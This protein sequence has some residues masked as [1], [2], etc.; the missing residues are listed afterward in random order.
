MV[1][2][3]IA[4][5]CDVR[6]IGVRM[7]Q[8]RI[9]GCN[10]LDTVFS[11]ACNALSKLIISHAVTHPALAIYK[12]VQGC[13]RFYFLVTRCN[14]YAYST[15]DTPSKKSAAFRIYFRLNLHK[16]KCVCHVFNLCLKGCVLRQAWMN[17]LTRL[18]SSVI[19]AHAYKSSCC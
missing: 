8:N 5:L 4:A 2:I 18:K 13:N 10:S 19:E 17:I 3:E 16:G 1:C 12:A 14:G 15:A 9:V 6:I 11:E 7:H